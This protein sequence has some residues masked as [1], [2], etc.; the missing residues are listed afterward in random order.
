MVSTPYSSLGPLISTRPAKVISPG[1]RE[2]E[3]I[4]E[5]SCRHSIAVPAAVKTLPHILNAMYR[6]LSSSLILSP[7]SWFSLASTSRRSGG[8]LFLRLPRLLQQLS[9]FMK[10]R[11]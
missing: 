6:A 1:T 9:P 4:S 11:C 7:S 8:T 3:D 10:I 2:F 5:A